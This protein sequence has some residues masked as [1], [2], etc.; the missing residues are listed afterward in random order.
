[1]RAT[2]PFYRPAHPERAWEA[3]REQV[4]VSVSRGE[5][6]KGPVKERLEREVAAALEIEAARVVAVGSGSAALALAARA[7]AT[8]EIAVPG[9]YYHGTMLALEMGGCKTRTHVDVDAESWCLDSEIGGPSCRIDVFGNPALADGDCLV[10]SAHSLATA[11]LRPRRGAIECFALT[12]SKPIAAGEGGL[13]V[14]NDPDLVGPVRYY[15]SLFSRLPE[16][17][18]TLAL[19]HWRNRESLVEDRMPAW[20]YYRQHL[21]FPTQKMRAGFSPAYFGMLVP[22]RAG[23]LAANAECGVEFKLYWSENRATVDL[24]VADSIRDR[25]VCL[26]LW[27]GVPFKQVVDSLRFP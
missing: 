6:T 1:M 7:I 23:F 11:D 26:P 12:A 4:S 10:D 16:M 13:I 17:S 20:D 18:A 2:I 9:Y 19:W 27:A 14:V 22:H 3:I 8:P 5:W 21:P 25:I 15:A 24:P